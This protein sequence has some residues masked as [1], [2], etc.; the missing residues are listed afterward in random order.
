MIMEMRVAEPGAID[1]A[2]ALQ[3][4]IDTRPY[5]ATVKRY[6]GFATVGWI[7]ECAQHQRNTSR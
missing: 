5:N 7:E 1:L 4:V 6:Q 2:R 3:A